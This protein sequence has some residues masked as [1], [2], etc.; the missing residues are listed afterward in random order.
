M[1]C[2]PATHAHF[3]L[4]LPSTVRVSSRQGSPSSMAWG[5]GPTEA[6]RGARASRCRPPGGG[7][8]TV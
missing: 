1:A 8:G 4:V 5:R 6:R 7:C 2:Y 3:P